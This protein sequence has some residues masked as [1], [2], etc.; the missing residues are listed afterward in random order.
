MLD[1]LIGS[2]YVDGHEVSVRTK[3][4]RNVP[5][6]VKAKVL[7]NRD[8]TVVGTVCILWSIVRNRRM[9]SIFQDEASFLSTLAAN[10][11]DAIIGFDSRDRIRSWNRGAQV[12]FG[13]GRDEAIGR[14]LSLILPDHR[15]RRAILEDV[16]TRMDESGIMT[17]CEMSAIDKQGRSLNLDVTWTPLHDEEGRPIGKSAVMRDV[18]EKKR[19]QAN[20]LHAQRLAVVG[21]MAAKIAHEVKNPLAS[22][23]LNIEMLQSEFEQIADRNTRR[24]ACELLASVIGEVER[25]DTITR[26]YLEYSCLPTMR[27]SWQDLHKML[28][29]LQDFM[30]IEMASRNIK[31]LCSFCKDLPKI[32]FDKESMKE[33]ILNLYKN[34]SEAMSLGGKIKTMTRVAGDWVEIL[35]SDTGPG[36]QDMDTEKLFEP[37]FSTKSMGT[38]LGLPIARDILVAHGG[39]LELCSGSGEGATFLLRLP[40]RDQG[41]ILEDKRGDANERAAVDTPGR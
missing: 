20:E 17:N 10:S 22:I 12:I 26:E 18:T 4:G 2:D 1:T 6:R 9:P 30:R 7:K 24:E 29:E 32:S 36:I 8:G 41:Y 39:S 25:L 11:L 31:F 37:F 14:G 21:Q 34:S 40:L 13:Y 28:R 33:A 5:C 38:G 3:E 16:R 35:I 27:F 15:M 23:R 19:L